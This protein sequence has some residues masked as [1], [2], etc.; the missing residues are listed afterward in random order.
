MPSVNT[1]KTPGEVLPVPHYTYVL[2][3]DE[4]ERYENL[5]RQLDVN[6]DGRID[7]QELSESLCKLGI[8][9]NLKHTYATVKLLA[10]V[11]QDQ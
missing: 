2:P 5:F 7:I 10:Q 8:P 11:L 1:S 3:A 9:E 4:E 6:G